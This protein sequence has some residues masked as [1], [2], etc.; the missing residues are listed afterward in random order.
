VKRTIAISVEQLYRP[1]PGG[2]ATYVRGLAS[3]LAALNDESLDVIGIAPRGEPRDG[4][5]L[6]TV[7]APVGVNLLTRLWPAW[8]LGVPGSADVVHATSMA[9]PFAG[10]KSGAVHSVSMHDLLWRDEA[11]ASTRSGIAF[12]ERRL[13]LIA[14]HDDLR[15]IV[16]APSLVE[17]L[18]DVGIEAGRVHA[19]RL[20]VND[21]GE[22]ASRESVRT[23]LAEHGVRGPFTLYVGTREPRKNI[24]RL[25]EAHRQARLIDGQLGNLVLVGPSG[26]GGVATG[27]ATVLGTVARPILNGL[28]RDATVVAY[29]P[30]AEGWGLPP[31]EALHAG[32]RVVA[33]VTT[34]SVHDNDEVVRVDPLDVNAIAQGLLTALALGDDDASRSR[35]QA[36]VADLTWR[37]VALD[38]LAA[39][40]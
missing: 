30:R 27:D 32:S 1:Q 2:I 3:G 38:H 21:P 17:R 12:H 16:T 35:R 33:S 7:H 5:A 14:S 18:A 11:A 24:E 9:G 10:G 8:P 23:L 20:G 26:W 19:V 13:K 31:V 15:V 39:W 4:L 25:L 40:R 28:Y 34:P 36:S 6:R 22:A 29:V 37:N